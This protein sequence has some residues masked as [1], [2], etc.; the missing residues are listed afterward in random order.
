MDFYFFLSQKLEAIYTVH[1]V[2]MIPARDQN[3]VFFANFLLS[4]IFD[5][6]YYIRTCS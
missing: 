3:D 2:F 4:D 6:T 1:S 5:D